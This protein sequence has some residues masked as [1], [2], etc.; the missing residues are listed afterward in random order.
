MRNY[1]K[2]IF[3]I[4]K[5]IIVGLLYVFAI[6]L[7]KICDWSK[8]TFQVGLEEII[9][10]ITSPLKGTGGDQVT[11]AVNYC[12]PAVVAGLGIYILFIIFDKNY[13]SNIVLQK[14]WRE[15]HFSIDCY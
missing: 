4:I 2:I 13:K 9:Y 7:Y 10:T 15:F 12:L 5:Y 1:K 14:C 11:Q 6:I 8:E 3:Q